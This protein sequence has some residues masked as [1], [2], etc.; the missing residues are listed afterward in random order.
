MKVKENVTVYICQFCKRKMFVKKSMERHEKL[1][2]NNPENFRACSG[3][4]FL[5]NTTIEYSYSVPT[6]G[7]NMG[8]V[9][10]GDTVERKTTGFFCSKLK[11]KIYPF[12]AEKMGLIEKYPETFE[13]Q[14][15]M[16]KTC[17]H[18]ND[19]PRLI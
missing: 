7:L 18:Y 9:F 8:V 6:I 14:Y 15:P 10:D 16:P 17:E 4:V 11:K 19:A 1:C 12:K 13:D 2:N 3:C 5:E